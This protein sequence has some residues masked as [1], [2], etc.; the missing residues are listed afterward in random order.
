MPKC[1]KA[2]Y[3]IR[4]TRYKLYIQ[5]GV[6]GENL[7]KQSVENEETNQVGVQTQRTDTPTNQESGRESSFNGSQSRRLLT[8]ELEI[9][10]LSK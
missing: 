2:T 8:N 7:S 10:H 6:W 1:A 3:E 9:P 4:D 5:R